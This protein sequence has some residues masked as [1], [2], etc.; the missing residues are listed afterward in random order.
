MVLVFEAGLRGGPFCWF[1]SHSTQYRHFCAS[2]TPGAPRG[3][4]LSGWGMM[5]RPLSSG[6]GIMPDPTCFGMASCTCTRHADVPHANSTDG[7]VQCVPELLTRTDCRWP[8]ALSPL[9]QHTSLADCTSAV[10]PS[11]L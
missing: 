3:V 9:G 2:P 7:R 6:Y 1:P 10:V 4:C 5:L 8:P 11:L